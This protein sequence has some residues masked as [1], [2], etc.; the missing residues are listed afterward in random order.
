VND[1]PRLDVQRRRDRAVED[2]RLWHPRFLLLLYSFLLRPLYGSAVANVN[3]FRRPHDVVPTTT[4]LCPPTSQND[5]EL[6]VM[7]AQSSM[8]FEEGLLLAQMAR[9]DVFISL[10]S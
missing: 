8:T 10:N 2:P 7:W 6:C 3:S 5:P 4:P 9:D 1:G